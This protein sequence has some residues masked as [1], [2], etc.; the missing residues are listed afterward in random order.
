M[1]TAARFLF[2]RVLGLPMLKGVLI[3]VC[4]LCPRMC[5][6]ERNETEGRG[7]CGLPS[8][9]HVARAALHFGEEPCISGERGSGTVFFGGCTLACAFCQNREISRTAAGLPVSAERLAAIF[10]ELE[11]QGAHNINLVSPTPWVATIRKALELR[12]PTVPVVYNS[13]GYERVE[14]LRSLEG[15]IDVYLPDVKYADDALALSLSGVP[16]YVETATAAVAEMVRQ[17]GRV[18]FDEQ[19]IALR[20]TIVRHL[21]LPG[22]TNDSLR[23][24][25]RLSQI[26]DIFVS[27]MFQYTPMDE[28][29]G[30][31]ELSRRLTQRECDKVFD[32]LVALGLTDGYVQSRESAGV[33]MIPVFDGTGVRV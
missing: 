30:H 16:N 11:A 22:H 29:D 5:A 33:A 1:P 32:R 31:R 10:E 26:D 25:E 18:Q 27:L 17:T 13:S 28:I 8:V 23:V 19:G 3:V 12:R 6:A 9:A 20:G 21:V 14:T 2:V 4:S 24:L 15:L 7:A